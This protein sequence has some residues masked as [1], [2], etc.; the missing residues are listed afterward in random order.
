MM[1]EA[2]TRIVVA[3]QVVASLSE[4]RA[5][6]AAAQER[7]VVAELESP[8]DAAIIYGVLWFSELNHMLAAEFA[9]DSFTLTLDCGERP[10]LA[11]NFVLRI[12]GASYFRPGDEPRR[13]V[14][15]WIKDG[16]RDRLLAEAGPAYA[17][18]GPEH[19]Y[20]HPHYFWSGN[21]ATIHTQLLERR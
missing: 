11:Q 16:V 1:S 18:A 9:A 10:D 17:P 15:V 3:S 7:S 20:T 5:A 14:A 8:P 19:R 12:P 21:I 6:I 2:K 4:A 13:V